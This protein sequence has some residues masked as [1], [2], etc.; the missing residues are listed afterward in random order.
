MALKTFAALVAPYKCCSYWIISSKTI[1]VFL[2]QGL[3]FDFLSA[4]GQ[5]HSG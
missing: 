1:L 2:V 3:T 5:A 4:L